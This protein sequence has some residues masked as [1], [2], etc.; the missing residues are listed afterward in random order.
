MAPFLM[1]DFF[2]D[3]PGQ[4]RVKNTLNNFNQ[5]THI[6]HALL[7]SGMEGTGKEF[8]A[9][10]FAQSINSKNS[11]TEDIERIQKQIS[12][13]SEPYIKY[14]IPLPRGRNETESD[15]PTD[16][17]NFEE[18]ELLR[19]ELNRKIV[20]PYYTFTLPKAN[21]IKINSI[22]EIKKFLSLDFSDIAFRFVIIESAHLMNEASQNALLKNLEEPPQG[23]IFIL[24][25]SYPERLR[26][27]IRSRC[28]K[29]NFDPLKEEELVEILIKYFDHD[30]QTAESVAPF[31]EG[32]IENALKLIDLDINNLREK[33]ISILR[34]SFGRK[35]HSALDELN[36]LLTDQSSEQ[37]QLII[38]M[39]L[40]WLN[41]LQ[42]HKQNIRNYFFKEHQETL[43]KFNS[44]FPDVEL[45]EV[46]FRLDRLSSYVKNNININLLTANIIFELSAL[47]TS[48]K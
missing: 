5:T 40:I 21:T 14:I 20:N 1:D 25:T 47:P 3:I 29:I 10:R 36:S 43:E 31:A 38:K 32:S 48:A 13:L 27:T 28:W 15:G 34:Y 46:V 8:F 33:T 41:D 9:V 11:R 39:L 44:K 42:K 12:T 6:P 17:L 2:N 16:K 7:F 18:V 26:E 37:I 4:D 35:Y 24:I 22:R 23:V 30:K 45:E 19:E